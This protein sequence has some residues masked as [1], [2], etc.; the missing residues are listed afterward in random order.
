MPSD[1]DAYAALPDGRRRLEALRW[2]AGES[3][4]DLSRLLGRPS[5]YLNDHVWR[6]RPKALTEDE[7]A[8]L[9]RYF[10]VCPSTLE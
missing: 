6:G 2:K 5:R 3:W 10:N 1:P 9:G 8:T 4:P 7:R